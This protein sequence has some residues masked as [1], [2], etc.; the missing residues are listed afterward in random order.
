[1]TLISYEQVIAKMKDAITTARNYLENPQVTPQH[2]IIIERYIRSV[3]EAIADAEQAEAEEREGNHRSL[4]TNP[5]DKARPAALR[6]RFADELPEQVKGWKA[7]T[8]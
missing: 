1:M 5:K 8:F 7:R 2:R 3:Q 6:I 4:N